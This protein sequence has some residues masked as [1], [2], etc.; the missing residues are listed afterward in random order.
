MKHKFTCA[1]CGQDKAHESDISTGY[2]VDD[3]GRKI[4][5]S[6]CGKADEREMAES[7]KY[8]LYLSR[9][10]EK[11]THG[12]PSYHWYLSNW[13]GTFEIRLNN[14]PRKGGHNIAGTRYDVWFWFDGSEWHGVQY[15]DWTQLCHCKRKKG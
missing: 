11:S 7:D 5:F 14:A 1:D 6:C 4:C 15:G 3:S 10:L 8:I 12:A 9:R 13:P 2:G